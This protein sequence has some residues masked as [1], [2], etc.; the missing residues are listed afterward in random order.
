MNRSRVLRSVSFCSIFIGIMYI[1][2]ISRK[3]LTIFG[4][5]YDIDFLDVNFW[6]ITII[7]FTILY[8]AIVFIQKLGSIGFNLGHRIDVSLIIISVL[9][10]FYFDDRRLLLPLT[11][12]ACGAII[13]SV[14]VYLIDKR[15]F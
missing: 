12:I 14:N 15:H 6:A 13:D 2:A 9:S 4:I 8:G 7:R 1:L 11:L 3:E 10:Y 5:E